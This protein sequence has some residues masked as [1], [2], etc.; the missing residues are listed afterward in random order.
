MGEAPPPIDAWMARERAALERE[1]VADRE[2]G[3]S[4]KS[5]LQKQL[6]RFN[7]VL[8]RDEVARPA[9]SGRR[10]LPPEQQTGNTPAGVPQGDFG[11]ELPPP[12]EFEFA[13]TVSG[14]QRGVARQK[15]AERDAKRRARFVARC[16]ADGIPPE[17][18]PPDT[19]AYVYRMVQGILSDWTGK[20]TARALEREAR[21]RSGYAIALLRNAVGG[22]AAD[23]RDY[24]TRVVIAAALMLLSLAKRVKRKGRWTLLV[25]GHSVANIAACLHR[26]GDRSA[27]PTR[28]AIG[29]G[30]RK[31][32]D[33]RV[34]A[35][36]ARFERARARGA[37]SVRS[38][39][40]AWDERITPQ[41]SY[42]PVLQRLRDVG[43]LYA[44]QLPAQCV[45][46]WERDSRAGKQ[47]HVR[48]RYWLACLSFP[49][50]KRQRRGAPSPLAGELLGMLQAEFRKLNAI[51]WD[52]IQARLPKPVATAPP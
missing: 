6:E 37:W 17:A 22:D 26:P 7:A 1:Q 24:G 27:V 33:R 2:R 29:G 48:N 40:R 30:G 32:P 5:K 41:S 12:P 14:S 16:E 19:P 10:A 47:H 49:E 46:A 51:G 39:S 38:K 21:A 3:E 34:A 52:W 43:F 4:A 11:D 28:N 13:P 50:M 25:S 23:F 8:E 36:T 42:Q 20:T 45:K 35:L 44:Q 9:E 31:S 18:I 15:Q